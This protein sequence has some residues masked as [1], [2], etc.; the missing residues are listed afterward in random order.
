ME[1]EGRYEGPW[2]L[3]AFT[4]AL[5]I[6]GAWAVAA[7]WYVMEDWPVRAA[8]ARMELAREEIACGN[9]SA[10]P[11][12]QQRCRDLVLSRIFRTFDQ[13]AAPDCGTCG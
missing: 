13:A 4:L 10:S 8:K 9:R 6:A 7:G 12:N 5:L 1:T 2:R 11:A 3:I